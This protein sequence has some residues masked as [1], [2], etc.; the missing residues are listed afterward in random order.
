MN[1]KRSSNTILFPALLY[2]FYYAASSCITP[3]LNIFFQDKGLSL[4]QIGI[5]AAMPN[6]LTLVAAPLWAG[7]A[8]YFGLHRRI[9]PLVM[10]LTIPFI[11]MIYIGGSFEVLLPG[12]IFY[13]FC[14][15]PIISLTD[16][17]VLS[18][19]GDKSLKYG[20]TR[21]WGS[22]SWAAMGWLTGW[23]IDRFGPTPAYVGFVIFMLAAVWL[24][25][26]LPEPEMIQDRHYW[27]NLGGILRDRRWI[28]FLSGSF[29]LGTAFNFLSNYIYLFMKSLGASASL[30]GMSVAAL[31]ILEI[32]VFIYTG[33]LLKKTA[34]RNLILFSYGVLIIR[35][36]LTARLVSPIWGVAL[37]LF[38]GIFF[39][40]YWT[41]A[42][43]YAH[44]IAPRGMSASAQALFAASFF[45]LGGITGAVAGG[46]LYAQY[47]A[48]FMFNVG[49]GLSAA[50]FFLFIILE[51]EPKNKTPQKVQGSQ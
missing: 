40:L 31:S 46:W 24:A 10:A 25:M 44:R 26:K 19:L 23:L 48:P 18:Y 11:V 27:H 9:L 3:Y 35:S 16:N 37:N 34:P 28:A 39:P 32:P 38:N 14:N 13:G 41:G 15:S 43:N 47:G 51:K 5:L 4:I 1:P 12:I 49:A 17:S 42:V 20:N 2:F 33:R 21:L 22:I 45:G 7:I 50:G 8:D 36:L 30:L 29:L 6:G